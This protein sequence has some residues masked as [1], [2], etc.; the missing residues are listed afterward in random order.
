MHRL[1]LLSINIT[2]ILFN[3]GFD[4]VVAGLVGVHAKFIRTYSRRKSHKEI[5]CA[6]ITTCFLVSEFAKIRYNGQGG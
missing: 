6:Q 2:V 3:M 5:H 1:L 4:D